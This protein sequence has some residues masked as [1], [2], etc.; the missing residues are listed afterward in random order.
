MSNSRVCE[1]QRRWCCSG[2]P[3]PNTRYL[4]RGVASP[5]ANANIVWTM[6]RDVSPLR[7]LRLSLSSTREAVTCKSSSIDLER[8]L[9]FDSG[10][11]EFNVEPSAARE[12][13]MRLDRRERIALEVIVV[14]HFLDEVFSQRKSH[15]R[16]ACNDVNRS[17]QAMSVRD[18]R[19]VMQA[20]HG[21]D[22]QQFRCAS[23]PLR[24]SL[25]NRESSRLQI[26][27]HFPSTIE[28]FA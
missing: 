24:V 19:N 23:A 5:N 26:S 16:L 11:V 1:A 3:A 7:V 2:I 27:L 15:R 6:G 25:N 13:D 21:S 9:R 4:T 20:G 12:G 10:R 18:D 14:L 17:T 8:R 22:T 28:V